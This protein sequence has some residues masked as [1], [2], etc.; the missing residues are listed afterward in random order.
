[1]SFISIIL[2]SL[3]IL[4]IDRFAQRTL[5]GFI[6]RTK[7]KVEQRR[8]YSQVWISRIW[9]GYVCRNKVE[10]LVNN[11]FDSVISIQCFW[12]RRLARKLILKLRLQR[13]GSLAIQRTF[14]GHLGRK[15]ARQE[16][17]KFIFARS[18]LSGIEFGRQLLVEHKLHATKLQS[19][20][21]LLKR[22]KDRHVQVIDELLNEIKNF[23][24][25]VH[26]LEEAMQNV[27]QKESRGINA[28]NTTEITAEKR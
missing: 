14:R 3:N 9:R 24:S 11:R 28:Y 13:N 25:H 16:R 2:Q 10:I 18:K 17:D 12:R 5:R 22:E 23:D 4:D 20:V 27:C 8:V 26:N 7:Y 15:F 6:N 19:E 21:S 1:M